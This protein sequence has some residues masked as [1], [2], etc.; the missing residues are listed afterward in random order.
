MLPT[1]LFARSIAFALIVMFAGLVNTFAITYGFIDQSNAF[2]NTGAFIVQLPDGRIYPICSGT[3][4]SSTVFLTA[5]HCTSYYTSDLA[6][7]G[8]KALISFDNPIPFG[9][10]TSNKT[11]LI[12]V[13]QVVTNP[14]YNQAQSDTGDIA[15]LIVDGRDTRGVTPATLPTAGLLDQL[16]VQNGLAGSKYTAAGY[17]LQ[18]RVVG[19][20]LPYFQD[21][22]P[23]PRMYSFSSFD[24]LN[25]TFLRLSQNPSTGDGGTCFGDSGGPNFLNVSGVRTLVGITITGDSVCRATNVT[26]RTDT[27]SARGFLAPYLTL[28]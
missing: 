23:I 19:G 1:K 20:G 18:N 25:N 14:N 21:Q 8:Y 13:T 6:P 15:V 9:S 2:S 4:I 24:A 11:K 17:G 3:L 5:S 26:Y 28:P 7:K 22:N 10:L 27:A 12:D 16:A